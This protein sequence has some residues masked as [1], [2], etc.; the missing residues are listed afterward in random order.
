[1]GLAALGTT[2]AVN[3]PGSVAKPALRAVE[4]PAAMLSRTAAQGCRGKDDM[5]DIQF[6]NQLFGPGTFEAEV[7]DNNGDP[8]SVLEAGAEFKVRTK[9]A[10]GALAALLLG[11]EWVVTVYV[12]SIGP[13]PERRIGTEI[14]P[15]NGSAN[16]SALVVV[17][18]NTLPD[19]PNPPVGGVY[20]LVTVL[21]HRNFGKVS[22]VAAIAEGPLV[23]IA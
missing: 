15:L 11:G 17:P 21:T 13:G 4:V 12:E 2:P 7:L 20:K 8:T 3:Q 18:A 23:R 10:I 14:V 1:M 5:A 9:W 19:D 6:P 22:D 16:Y